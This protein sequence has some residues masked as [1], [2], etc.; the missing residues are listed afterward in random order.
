MF[1]NRTETVCEYLRVYRVRRPYSD[2]G[3]V[4]PSGYTECVPSKG[5]GL[6]SAVETCTVPR[7]KTEADV[8]KLDSLR[9]NLRALSRHRGYTASIIIMRVLGID[10]GTEYTGYGVVD[11][12][13]DGRAND[14]LVCMVCGAI[15]ASPKDPMAKR[16]S[17]IFIGL[18][19]L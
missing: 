5:S 4:V 15:K 10:C 16:L 12:V 14:R 2:S 19:E 6:K 18:Q 7:G 1:T 9:F 13:S 8:G 17:R 11:L 3:I